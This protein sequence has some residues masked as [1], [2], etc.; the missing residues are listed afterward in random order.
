M[1]VQ[2]KVAQECRIISE[3]AI[4][5]NVM[6]RPHHRLERGYR[7]FMDR[8][9]TSA[10]KPFLVSKRLANAISTVMKELA[11]IVSS[12]R[13]IVRNSRIVREDSSVGLTVPLTFSAS[14]SP[15]DVGLPPTTDWNSFKDEVILTGSSQPCG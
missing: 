9:K 5:M 14:R 10:S 6:S 2:Q 8:P 12:A 4:P 15:E 13:L 1:R 11:S 3:N 7:L